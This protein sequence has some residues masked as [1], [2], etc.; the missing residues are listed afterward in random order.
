MPTTRGGVQKAAACS[1]SPAWSFL[2]EQGITFKGKG[3][4]VKEAYAARA[5]PPKPCREA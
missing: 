4:L 5:T 2:L 1:L 3:L